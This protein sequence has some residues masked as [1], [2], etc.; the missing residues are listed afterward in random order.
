MPAFD[1]AAAKAQQVASDETLHGEPE[2][3]EVPLPPQEDRTMPAMGQGAVMR[4]RVALLSAADGDARVMVLRQG[5]QPPE[6]A[7]LAMVIPASPKDAE[8]VAALLGGPK[9]DD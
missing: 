6:G 3:D 9:K 1:L 7:A 2:S 4:W 5:A 8:T